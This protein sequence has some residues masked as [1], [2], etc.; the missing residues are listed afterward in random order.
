MNSEY[1][2]LTPD[3]FL[4]TLGLRDLE[5]FVTTANQ[6][7]ALFRVAIDYMK[8]E[9]KFIEDGSAGW[10]GEMSMRIPGSALV[11][12]LGKPGEKELAAILAIIAAL[13]GTGHLDAKTVTLTAALAIMKRVS[14]VKAEYGERSII[15]IVSKLP[16]PTAKDVTLELFGNKC[17]NPKASCRY[18]TS[19][20]FC[21]ISLEQVEAT[22]TSLEE[23]EIVR[24]LNATPPIEYGIVV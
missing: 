17:R 2:I 21:Q 13:M 22:I 20:D 11:V 18:M 16:R 12:R 10:H 5:S 14:K 23:R 3:A 19:N 6:R 24:K 7:D 15:E 9:G 1:S 4:R 8:T